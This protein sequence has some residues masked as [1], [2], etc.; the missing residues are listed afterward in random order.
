M[1]TLRKTLTK[2]ISRTPRGLESESSTLR[3]CHV[4]SKKNIEACVIY[5]TLRKKALKMCQNIGKIEHPNEHPK[6]LETGIKIIPK[7]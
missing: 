6:W 2:I 5:R 7:T 3:F 4:L 1:R